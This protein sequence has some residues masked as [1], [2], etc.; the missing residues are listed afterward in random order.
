MI[1]VVSQRLK[2]TVENSTIAVR[3]LVEKAPIRKSKILI[4]LA[5]S[6]PKN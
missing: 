1:P 6:S 2:L 3:K 4:Q 5:Q